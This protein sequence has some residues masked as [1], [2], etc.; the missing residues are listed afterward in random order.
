MIKINPCDLAALRGKNAR[1]AA[2][3]Q[4]AQFRFRFQFR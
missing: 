4:R 3:A 1:K 2:K